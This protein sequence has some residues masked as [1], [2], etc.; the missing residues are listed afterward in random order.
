MPTSLLAP[1]CLSRTVYLVALFSS[2]PFSL[3]FHRLHLRSGCLLNICLYMFV[4][5]WVCAAI[6]PVFKQLAQEYAGKVTFVAVDVDEA[7]DIATK[8]DITAMPTFKFL[9]GGKVVDELQGADPRELKNKL[10]KLAAADAKPAGAA[11]GSIP[12]AGATSGTGGADDSGSRD[13]DASMGKAD[14]G[15]DEEEEMRP[16]PVMGDELEGDEA[17]P[18]VIP[19]GDRDEEPFPPVGDE[20]AE[21]SE[22]DVDKQMN[23]KMEASELAS[24]GDLAAAL[25][26]W[27]AVIAMKPSPLALAK[28]ADVLLKLK[29]PNA[30]VHDCEAALKMNPDS[31]KSLKTR[32][33]AYRLLGE[34]EKASKDLSAGIAIDFDE[35][36]AETQKIVQAHWVR[37]REK[38]LKHDAEMREWTKEKDAKD[39]SRARKKVQRE[40]EAQ[41]AAE[42]SSSR[43]MPDGMGG[44]MPGMGGMG[45][46]P[47]MPNLPPD[48]QEKM[49]VR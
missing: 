45:G 43:D 32:G 49:K 48:V 36:S 5:G 20:S 7:K 29:K 40:Y 3:L 24:T 39:R 17:D 12:G 28:R 44:D 27:N 34:W 35:D 14:E 16:M 37:I 2:Y 26:K 46:M 41:K 38:R 33:K 30:A 22:A 13:G 21:L 4:R 9:S 19:V 18:D 6:K 42:E 1:S 31:A 25:Q 10:A 8:F 23:L 47:G 11:D 15:T